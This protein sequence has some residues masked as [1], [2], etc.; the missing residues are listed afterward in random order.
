MSFWRRG[1]RTARHIYFYPANDLPGVVL[2]ALIAVAGLA[3]VGLG[4]FHLTSSPRAG[5]RDLVLTIVGAAL[6]LIG[7]IQ[8]FRLA[9]GL[10]RKP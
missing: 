7:T 3:M 1:A 2:L 6:A 4:V 9:R 8:S 5:S 10:R